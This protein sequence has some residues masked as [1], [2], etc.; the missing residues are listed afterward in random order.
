MRHNIFALLATLAVLLLC[1]PACKKDPNPPAAPTPPDSLHLAQTI[2]DIG[3]FKPGSY[4][5][6][7]DSATGRV[8][9]QWIEQSAAF[10]TQ[11]SYTEGAEQYMRT[12]FGSSLGYAW[13]LK[14]KGTPGDQIVERFAFGGRDYV[15]YWPFNLGQDISAPYSDIDSI[16]MNRII[17][18]VQM[19]FGTVGPVYEVTL[20]PGSQTRWLYGT[21]WFCPGYGVIRQEFHEEKTWPIQLGNTDAYKIMGDWKLKRAH[22]IQ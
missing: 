15:F 18:S 22:I 12:Y 13:N 14:T 6:Y 5:V 9:S 20:G 2:L 8:D 21:I 17:G 4:W 10:W 16:T 3:Y 7:E 11:A 19:P 1:T